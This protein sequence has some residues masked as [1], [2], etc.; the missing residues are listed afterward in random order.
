MNKTFKIIALCVIFAVVIVSVVSGVFMSKTIASLNF[1]NTVDFIDELDNEDETVGMINFLLIGIDEDGTRSDT[2]MLFSYDGYSKRGNIL[3]LHRDTQVEMNGYKQKLNA[4]MGV[5][6]QKVKEGIDKEPEEELIRQVKKLTGLP[7]NYFM[8]IDFDAFIE[9]IDE[10]GGVEFDVPYDMDYDDPAQDLHIHL[11]KG[12]QHLDGQAAH[13]FVRFR[14]N[15]DGTAPGEYI[16]GDDGRIYWQQEFMKELF[17]QKAKPQYFAEL[18][19]IFEVIR[20]N[21]KTNYTMQDLLKHINLI[22][23]FNVEE[24][25]S[26]KLPGTAEYTDAIWWYICNE[27]QTIGLINDVFL[28]RSAEEWEKQKAEA[29]LNEAEPTEE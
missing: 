14:H 2:I 20:D 28:P 24:I 6:I 11:S 17:R 18:K 9:I 10:L 1:G 21:V 8:T 25:Q 5:G 3:S 16:Y 22:E 7:V 15:N 29:E 26:Y 23:N 4:A 13:D 19:D 12:Q 27:D